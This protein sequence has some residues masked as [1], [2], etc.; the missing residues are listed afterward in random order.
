M[1]MDQVKD[2][3]LSNLEKKGGRLVD[4]CDLESS[5]NR[6]SVAISFS[7]LEGYNEDNIDQRIEKAKQVFISRT[8]DGLDDFDMILRK[9]DKDFV[10]VVLTKIV[11]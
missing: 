3:V 4:E 11:A 10:I 8:S 5:D 7:R 9:A 1:H 6:A 2:V